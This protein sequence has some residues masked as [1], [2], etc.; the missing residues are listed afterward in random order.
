MTNTKTSRTLLILG[1]L[2]L[3]GLARADEEALLPP[4]HLAG[5]GFQNVYPELGKGR[6]FWKFVSWR[7]KSLWQDSRPL[8]SY[9]FPVVVPEV[10]LLRSNQT[11]TTVTWIG[12]AT[13]LV[14]YKGKNI[15]TDP[16]FSYR[17]SPVQWIGPRRVVPPIPDLDALPDIDLVILSHDHYDSLD[18]DSIRRL[19]Q[20]P[21][22]RRPMFYV[23][24]GIK[25]WMEAAGIDSTQIVELDWWQ[26]AKFENLKIVALPG[27]HF[28]RRG[29]TDLNRRLWAAWAVI[30]EDFRFLFL[31]DTAR[32]PHF[33][34]IGERYGPFDLAALPIGAYEPNWLM[35]RFHVNPEESVEA[36]IA[37]RS[38][39]SVAMHWGTFK[40]TDEPLDE[41]PSKL[42]QALAA[43][44]ISTASFRALLH[45][46]TLILP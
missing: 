20:R 40:L 30:A 7:W 36:H 35:R 14:Q 13:L 27:Q 45:G 44:K 23:P 9:R 29:L 16:H 10:E 28:C 15:L 1:C 46:E 39:L 6:T 26:E 21:Q 31:G 17:A 33:E 42:D 24:L 41:P 19:M 4:H 34:A 38:K 32:S 25:E 3:V 11:R 22:Q 43:K 12:H 18:L 5:G 8:E 37:T 2:A